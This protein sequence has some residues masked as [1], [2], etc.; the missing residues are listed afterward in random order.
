MFKFIFGKKKNECFLLHSIF[1]VTVKFVQNYVHA[2]RAKSVP[3]KPILELVLVII[4][5]IKYNK[6]I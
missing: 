6:T 2:Q 3:F 5:Y 1:R 4:I